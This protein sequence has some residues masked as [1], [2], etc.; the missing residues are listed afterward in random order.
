MEF[1]RRVPGP[2]HE[3]S[4]KGVVSRDRLSSIHAIDGPSLPPDGSAGEEIS[5]KGIFDL[6]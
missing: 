1:S 6:F 2:S 3:V 5:A 4:S